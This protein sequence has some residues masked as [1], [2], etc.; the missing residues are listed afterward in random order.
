MQDNQTH[1]R[2]YYFVKKNARIISTPENNFHEAIL[3][4]S[5]FLV[6]A[7][8]KTSTPPDSTLTYND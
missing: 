2:I 1:S 6:S 8:G 5:D 3:G 4:D 7:K